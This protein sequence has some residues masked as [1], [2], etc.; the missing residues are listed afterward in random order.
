M[1][2]RG[3]QRLSK[4]F[5][6]LFKET[7]RGKGKTFGFVVLLQFPFSYQSYPAASARERERERKWERENTEYYLLG[8]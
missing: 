6:E 5:Q 8:I 4:P 7:I 1:K 3:H 2:T